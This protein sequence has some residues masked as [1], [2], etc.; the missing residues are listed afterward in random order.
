MKRI[1]ILVFISFVV[2]H[3]FSIA[4]VSIATIQITGT[5]VSSDDNI[6]IPGVNI[7]EKGTQNGTITDFDGKFTIEVS[8]PDAIL[9]FS[10][11][12]FDKQEVQVSGKQVISIQL[13][14]NVKAI[15]E[16]VVIGYGTVK[17]SDLTGSVTSV[18]AGDILKSTSPTIDMRIQ[19][20]ASGVQVMQNS[21]A[22]GGGISIRI[23]G[24][25][26]FGSAN[27]PLYVVDGYPIQSSSTNMNFLNPSDIES[28][29]ILKDA[30]ATAIYGSR[31]ANGVIL[32]TTKRGKSGKLRVDYDQTYSLQKP[33]NLLDMMNASEY[34]SYRNIALQ[35]AGGKPPYDGIKWP[36]P[37]SIGTGTDWQKE[38]FRT[39]PML[40]HNLT[41]A[42]GKDELTFAITGNYLSQKGIVLNSDFKRLTL[43]SNVDGKIGKMLSIGTNL[44]ISRTTGNTANVDG[45]SGGVVTAALNA[46]PYPS[47]YNDDGTINIVHPLGAKFD[48]PLSTIYGEKRDFASN[49]LM[50]NVY[51]DF[52]IVKSLHLKIKFGGELNQNNNDSYISRLTKSGTAE[53]GIASVAYGTG[54]GYL[55]ENTLTYDLNINDVHKINLLAGYTQQYGQWEGLSAGGKGFINDALGVNA[56]NGASVISQ[57]DN[58]FGENALA[59]YLGRINYSL[60]NKYLI[61]LTGRADGASNFGKDNKW[62][63]F[64]SVALGWK[65]SEESFIKNLNLFSTL[66]L[67]GSY[68][69]TGNSSFSPFKSLSSMVPQNYSFNDRKLAIGYGPGQP[70]NRDLRWETT[71]MQ[72]LGLDIGILENRIS[73]TVDMYKNQT[74]DVLMNVPISAVSGFSSVFGNAGSVENK[75]IELSL[76]AN[77][78]TK[79]FLWEI[80]ANISFNKNEITS[81]GSGQAFRT[82]QVLPDLQVYGSW[83]DVGQSIGVWKGLV[84]N[85]V[86]H[87]A[88]E[89]A[90]EP[91][92]TAS[93]KV[94]YAKYKDINNDGVINAEDEVII[95]DPNPDYIFGITNSFSYKNFD[96]SFYIYGVMGNDIRN[97]QRM[98]IGQG[99]MRSDNCLSYLLTEAWSPSNTKADVPMLNAKNNGLDQNSSYFIEDGSFIRF[100]SLTLGYTLPR[101]KGLQNGRVFISARNLFTITDYRGYDPEVNLR[102]QDIIERGNDFNAYPNSRSLTVGFSLSF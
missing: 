66:K 78:V 95:G 11:I 75:G 84:Y 63:I 16:V 23:R 6:P 94:G 58:Y 20:K 41:V 92:R 14:P 54:Y 57:P 22:P 45:W 26:S 25:N 9:V 17:K 46:D 62:G 100:S 91:K 50:G 83:V 4:N 39:A 37:D 5:V 61:T 27:E 86:F 90:A 68:G 38:L 51:A 56:L 79:P 34:A 29:E 99:G 69:T 19:G 59:S 43:K 53:G 8:S 12:G 96:L 82:S 47:S 87:D 7:F 64:P 60:L 2:L 77:V 40:N 72:N 76:N 98:Q 1:I 31:G 101:S 30:S 21:A 102:G 55:N 85:G 70:E 81:L 89:L 93:D 74:K 3:T 49:K 44:F 24:S 10:Y 13:V 67:R 65:M 52:E 35:N 42:G 97:I 36:S 80:N 33:S 88:E 71:T 32:I 28:I 18:S 15:D 73:F 48:N